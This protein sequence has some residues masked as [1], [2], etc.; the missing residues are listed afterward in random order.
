MSHEKSFLR[1]MVLAVGL[2]ALA[3]CSHP[4][5]MSSAE[6]A[7]RPVAI[8]NGHPIRQGVLDTFLGI[9]KNAPSQLSP[10]I[11]NLALQ[12]LVDIRVLAEKGRQAGLLRS[13]R[14]RDSLFLQRQVLLANLE[15]RHYLK[16][17]PIT[18]AQLQSAYTKTV[19]RMGHNEYKARHILVKTQAQAKALIADLEHGQHFST[20]AKKFSEDTT[21]A[22]G[23]ELGWVSASQE[24]PPFA[25]ALRKLKVGQ[26]THVP[27]KT[28]FGWHVIELQGKRPIT[29]PSFKQMHSRLL[30]VLRNK[31]V[32]AFITRLR[33]QAKVKILLK[34]SAAPTGPT[35]G[36]AAPPAKP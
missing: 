30:N 14:A 7:N 4:A 34:P 5:K 31:E 21:A 2:V 10:M 25:A 8:V 23:G 3:A 6:S 26:Y 27:V 16:T 12:R 22:D 36:P 9:T 13:P 32:T 18:P 29:P 33:S 35:T 15:I 17:H 28:Q 11:Q 19:G 24:T 1:A 20:L